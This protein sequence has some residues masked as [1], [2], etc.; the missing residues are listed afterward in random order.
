MLSLVTRPSI[1]R[2]L[3][4]QPSALWPEKG[5]DDFA[6]GCLTCKLASSGVPPQGRSSERQTT[7]RVPAFQFSTRAMQLNDDTNRHVQGY[8]IPVCT[9]AVF[10][11]PHAAQQ[12]PGRVATPLLEYHRRSLP[13]EAKFCYVFMNIHPSGALASL[14]AGCSPDVVSHARNARNAC[15]CGY[16]PPIV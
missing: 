7:R 1:T 12:A 16:K 2:L 3:L 4:Q 11:P 6:C 10:W 13:A 9:R 14:S 5:Q 8:Y 15:G